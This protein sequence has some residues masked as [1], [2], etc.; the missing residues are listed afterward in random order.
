MVMMSWLRLGYFT[1]LVFGLFYLVV[2]Q[3]EAVWPFT[4]DDMYI[5]LRY[6]KHWSEGMGLVWNVGEAP[7]EGYSNFS[8][9]GL[10]RLAYFLQLNPV[11]VLKGAGVVGLLGAVFGL[12]LLSRLW[13][14]ARMAWIPCVWLLAYR[15]QILWSVSGLETTVYESLVIFSVYF[16]LRGLGYRAY[17]LVRSTPCRGSWIVAGICLAIASMTRPEA[18]ALMILFVGLLMADGLRKPEA[19]RWR[20]VVVFTA[21][22]M[23]IFLPYFI[24]RWHYY[25]RLFPNPVYCKGGMSSLNL[26]LDGA[27]LRL[28]WPFILCALPTIFRRNRGF[29]FLGWPSLLYLG[30]CFGADPVVAFDNRLFLPSFALLL[31]LA[32]NGLVLLLVCER[33]VYAAAALVLILFIPTLSLHGYRQFT[34][35]PKAGEHLREQVIAWL[36]KETRSEDTVVLADSGLIPYQSRLR[37]T[38]SYCLNNASM[39]RGPQAE[40]YTRFCQDVLLGGPSVI[41][42]T[43]LV[44]S[45]VSHYTPADFCLA[46]GLS[47]SRLYRQKKVFR[48]P[49]REGSFYEYA[50]YSKR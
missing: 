33:R 35:N 16:I 24:M 31:P 47:Q 49:E 5:T 48:S 14:I 36:A 34:E 28:A 1:L 21:A 45:G 50:V 44:E 37:F 17:P 25:G 10:A 8:F 41:I 12:F 18:P 3:I 30:L 23:L 46:E 13:F 32:L 39:T 29:G 19:S 9:V 20:G 22:F 6:A 38:D 26:S 27:Y 40:R 11:T 15:G 43:A 2:F 42:L 4:I 7:V